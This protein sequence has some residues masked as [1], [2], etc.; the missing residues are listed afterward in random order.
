MDETNQNHLKNKK[1]AKKNIKQITHQSFL[2][3]TREKYLVLSGYFLKRIS[4]I[5]P[6]SLC[7][8]RKNNQ[9]DDESSFS[10]LD[11]SGQGECQPNIEPSDG[12]EMQQYL[13]NANRERE[14]NSV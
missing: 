5:V 3:L 14:N 11:C 6:I 10:G 4:H 2:R 8:L 1:H 12:D 7:D 13:E 9:V